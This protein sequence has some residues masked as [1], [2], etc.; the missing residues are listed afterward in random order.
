MTKTEICDRAFN[1][2]SLEAINDALI[3]GC[4]IEMIQRSEVFH[5]RELT[6]IADE[7]AKRLDTR[8][9][10][11]AGPSSSSKTTT[12]KRLAMHL[13]VIGINPVVIGMDDYFRNRVD[14]PK[15]EKGEYDFE[16][17]GA[18]DV[19]FLNRQ[20]N[21]LFEGKEVNLPTFDFVKGERSFNPEN[22]VTLK[23]NDV[24]V[25]EGIHGLNPE[26][27][28]SIAPE[29]KYSIY[30]GV[31]NGPIVP[32]IEDTAYESVVNADRLLR[33]MVRDYQFRGNSP[34]DTFKRWQ[35]VR[36]GEK[37]NIEPFKGNADVL[38]DSSLIYEIPL[39]K[40]YV[41][42]LLRSVP[43]SSP[44]YVWARQMLEFIM[45]RIVALTPKE[46]DTIPTTSVIREFIGGSSFSY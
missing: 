7:I 11:I 31:L 41:D 38:F 35:S 18:L 3:A 28:S 22:K 1:E 40:C 8:L 26:L 21:E 5:S 24:I 30:A 29:N 45:T 44:A 16:C 34:I 15:D 13:K 19:E 37:K 39:F 36:A 46:V 10:L 9:I 25:M 32:G 43:E 42:P 14:T 33:R 27:T 17:I 6:T 12:S 4:G 2:R 20:L 23:K